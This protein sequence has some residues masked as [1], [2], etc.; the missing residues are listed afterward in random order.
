MK[1]LGSSLGLNLQS[2]TKLELI[3]SPIKFIQKFRD[4]I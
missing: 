4:G 1:M 3:Q 2:S